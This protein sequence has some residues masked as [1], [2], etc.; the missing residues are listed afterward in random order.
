VP[1]ASPAVAPSQQQLLAHAASRLWLGEGASPQRASERS[2]PVFHQLKECIVRNVC[3]S[4]AAYLPPCERKLENSNAREGLSLG[5]V[6]G[7][8]TTTLRQLL[9]L[10]IL[11]LDEEESLFAFAAASE[12]LLLEKKTKRRDGKTCAACYGP[13][14][15][16]G[17][18]SS[19]NADDWQIRSSQILCR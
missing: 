13:L 3:S 11:N 18:C 9:A 12:S 14:I 4:V 17:F 19:G 16:P 1:A 7:G 5:K 10:S 2:R 15:M 8:T 6:S